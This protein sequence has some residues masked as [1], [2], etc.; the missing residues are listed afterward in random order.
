MSVSFEGH[1]E[2]GLTVGEVARVRAGEILEEGVNGGQ[3]GITRG[4][5]IV[6]V[7]FQMIEKAAKRISRE[8]FQCQVDTGLP[9]VPTRE[10]QEEL[11]RIAISQHGMSTEA[12]LGG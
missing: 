7:S 10:L 11:P 9:M 8:V 3:A 12:T 2:D 1:R 6:A 4:R 5:G